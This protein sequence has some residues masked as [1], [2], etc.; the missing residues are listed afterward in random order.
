MTPLTQVAA[1]QLFPI[2]TCDRRRY[3]GKVGKAIGKKKK[4]KPLTRVKNVNTNVKK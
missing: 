1:F 4:Q 2:T 3:I